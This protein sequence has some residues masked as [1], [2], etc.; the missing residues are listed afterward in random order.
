MKIFNPKSI[1]RKKYFGLKKY[2]LKINFIV[3][4]I[5][6]K[7]SLKKSLTKKSKKLKKKKPTHCHATLNEYTNKYI[8]RFKI[9]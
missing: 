7:R 9:V 4:T 6:I 3:K 1:V 5:K 8:N 2:F